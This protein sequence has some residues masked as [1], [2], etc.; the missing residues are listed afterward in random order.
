MIAEFGVLTVGLWIFNGGLAHWLAKAFPG[1]VTFLKVEIG[2]PGPRV[3]VFED[4]QVA[5]LLLINGSNIE[6]I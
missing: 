4:W 1:V 6:M 2:S 5:V 3:S